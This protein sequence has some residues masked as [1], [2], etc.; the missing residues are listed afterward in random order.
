MVKQ[1]R[2]NLLPFR[3][4]SATWMLEEG[5]RCGLMVASRISLCFCFGVFVKRGEAVRRN[6]YSAKT[7]TCGAAEFCVVE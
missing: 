3:S 1:S 4:D 7:D 6:S 2:S 5:F